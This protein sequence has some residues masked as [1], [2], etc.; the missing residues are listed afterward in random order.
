MQQKIKI[1]NKK[2]WISNMDKMMR[3]EI[4]E[5]GV[6]LM[7]DIE[8]A[9]RA[10]EEEQ[11]KGRKEGRNEWKILQWRMGERSWNEEKEGQSK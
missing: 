11:D 4:N 5:K 8:K 10:R 1:K 3:R 6:V 7:I 9:H 2:W